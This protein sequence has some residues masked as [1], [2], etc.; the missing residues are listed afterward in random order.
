MGGL[1]RGEQG[2]KLLGGIDLARQ[3]DGFDAGGAGDVAAVDDGAS[4]QGVLAGVDGAG[5]EANA[6]AEVVWKAMGPGIKTA[7]AVLEGEGV[8]QQGAGAG[9]DDIEG[10]AP[11]LHQFGRGADAPQALLDAGQVVPKARQFLLAQLGE[12]HQIGEKQGL[13][14]PLRFPG[15]RDGEGRGDGGRGVQDRGSGGGCNGPGGRGGP[16]GCAGWSECRGYG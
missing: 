1:F 3:G 16:A 12:T 10:V 6:Q 5:V 9:H 4:G 8:M 15:R 2:D 7:E 14:D 11:T 13:E